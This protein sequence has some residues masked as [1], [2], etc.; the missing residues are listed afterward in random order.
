MAL[1]GRL[2]QRRHLAVALG[3]LMVIGLLLTAELSVILC[4]IIG[5]FVLGVQYGRFRKMIIWFGVA[6]AVSVVVVGPVLGQRL[7][8]QFGFVAGSSKSALV[9]QTVSYRETIW[10]QQYL[11]AVAQ[12]PLEG[13][14]IELPSTISWPYPE[15][16][17]IAL[18]IEGGYPLLIMYLILLWGMFRE[19]RRASRSWDPVQQA[20]G[21]S[22]AV[23]VVS[24]V[25]VGITWPF[26]SNGGL[27]QVLWCLFALCGP[28]RNQLAKRAPAPELTLTAPRPR[29]TIHPSSDPR[30]IEP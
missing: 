29:A 1:A 23:G 16:Q 6:A 2:K 13:Y 28:V 17:Y 27:P 3:G 10:T 19:A 18:L 5:L 14:G 15:S 21:R 9:P 12:R 7:N 11:P 30:P 24:L 22:L 4:L 26:L 20:L 25:F 8:N